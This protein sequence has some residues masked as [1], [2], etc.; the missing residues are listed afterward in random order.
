M[1]VSHRPARQ[2]KSLQQL[3]LLPFFLPTL[4]SANPTGPA[5]ED[6]LVARKSR[7]PQAGSTLPLEVV[8]LTKRKALEETPQSTLPGVNCQ[9]R[10]AAALELGKTGSTLHSGWQ[11]GWTLFKLFHNSLGVG[12]E[13][14]K[15]WLLISAS[16]FE[17]LFC[18]SQF[19]LGIIL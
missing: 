18:P 19:S 4:A 12:M 3:L 11:G 17:L 2:G 5:R 8:V 9:L 1:A 7:A 6:L 10:S 15:T 13:K 14:R 16:G